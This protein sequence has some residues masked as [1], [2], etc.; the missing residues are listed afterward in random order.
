VL[1]ITLQAASK[2]SHEKVVQMLL[3]RGT[4][5]NAQGGYGNALQTASGQGHEKVVDMLLDQGTE[6]E[7]SR[8]TLWQC[9]AGCINARS[10]EGGADATQERRPRSTRKGKL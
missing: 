3:D 4:D 6:C 1:L 8:R 10:R 7:C 9:T 2:G 5:V